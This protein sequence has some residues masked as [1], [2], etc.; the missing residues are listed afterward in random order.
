MCTD[1]LS[2][3]LGLA[4]TAHSLSR[5]SAEHRAARRRAEQEAAE[6]RARAVAAYAERQAARQAERDDAG[7]ALDRNRRAALRARSTAE[8]RA[9]EAGRSGGAADALLRDLHAREGR[10]G[11]EAAAAD[12]Q[13][14]AQLRRELEAVERGAEARANAIRT[15]T[16]PDYL[17][18]GLD[19]GLQIARA[20]K[21]G[22]SPAGGL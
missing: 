1:P 12:R 11:A 6:N 19:A 5:Q 3:G 9:A 21:R 20:I 18:A 8:T 7:R 13:Q 10:Y 4:Q 16:P 22:S 17:G 14:E 2:L 15:P